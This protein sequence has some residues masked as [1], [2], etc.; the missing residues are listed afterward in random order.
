[1]A[2]RCDCDGLLENW[3]LR[4]HG[5]VD[6]HRIGGMLLNSV[7]IGDPRI[8]MTR[9]RVTA[10]EMGKSSSALS[11][12]NSGCKPG[13]CSQSLWLIAVFNFLLMKIRHDPSRFSTAAR[14]QFGVA[15][16]IHNVIADAIATN[17]RMSEL[18]G[19]AQHHPWSPAPPA[20]LTCRSWM[21]G[22]TP[23]TGIAACRRRESPSS[24][25]R[26]GGT[27]QRIP[28]AR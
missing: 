15:K 1:M 28:A 2:W 25:V 8:P 6:D 10:G 14:D 3:I 22:R 9:A 16:T 26:A 5:S 4:Q 24:N 20:G 17:L 19:G 27:E 11:G 13:A 12:T 21:S 23:G 7:D 18:G